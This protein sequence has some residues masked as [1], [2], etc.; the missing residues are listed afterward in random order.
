MHVAL[1]LG[2]G[3]KSGTSKGVACGRSYSLHEIEKRQLWVR[4]IEWLKLNFASCVMHQTR[5]LSVLILYSIHNMVFV[6]WTYD[7]VV[8]SQFCKFCGRSFVRVLYL[9]LM[10][11]IGRWLPWM[12]PGSTGRFFHFYHS[13]HWWCYITRM[14]VGIT[15]SVILLPHDM[16]YK[17]VV[18]IIADVSLHNHSA[19]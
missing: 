1:V 12:L 2:R 19:Q 18:V 7:M 5:S 8:I 14:E 9:V 3:S 11:D 10:T 13:L 15:V 6:N 4:P 16:V 17:Q